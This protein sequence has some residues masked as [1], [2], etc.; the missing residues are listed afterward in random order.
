V[1]LVAVAFQRSE[2]QTKARP[3]A[4]AS[5]KM[6]RFDQLGHAACLSAL[7]PAHTRAVQNER[8]SAEW[9]MLPRS[10]RSAALHLSRL[11]DA[12]G[13]LGSAGDYQVQQYQ[14]PLCRGHVHCTTL[15][16]ILQ[17]DAVLLMLT[18]MLVAP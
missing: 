17:N 5:W 2:V 16:Y 6:V 9:L 11:Q 7:T 1:W 15:H 8:H 12:A 3:V 4:R 13:L 14:P 18:R 10:H